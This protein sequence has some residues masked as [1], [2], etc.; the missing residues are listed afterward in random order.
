MVGLMVPVWP[1]PVERRVGRVRW[2]L[3]AQTSQL[4]ADTA[5]SNG[6]VLASAARLLFPA[7][8]R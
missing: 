8:G 2:T 4:L 5:E 3:C 6:L 7:S 1:G